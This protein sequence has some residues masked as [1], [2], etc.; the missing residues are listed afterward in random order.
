MTRARSKVGGPRSTARLISC[1]LY[2][3]NEASYKSRCISQFKGS[4]PPARST[5][6]G[7]SPYRSGLCPRWWC[8]WTGSLAARAA[9]DLR[10]KALKGRNIIRRERLGYR[11]GDTDLD[12]RN[13]LITAIPAKSFSLSVT[14]V[15]PWAS[16]TA[17]II[18]SSALRGR[19]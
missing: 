7:P 14:T 18:V 19:P 9:P 8:N 17:A 4:H 13:G 11:R 5:E 3:H 10:A 15:H 2:G 12:A 6:A 16:A 1:M